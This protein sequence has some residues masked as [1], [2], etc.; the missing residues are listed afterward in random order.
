MIRWLLA[1][2][3]VG[4][5][6]ITSACG[7]GPSDDQCKQLLEHL[8]DLEFKKGGAGTAANEGA[9]ADLAK[10]KAAV[11]E[12]KSAEFMSACVERTHVERVECALAASDVAA[13][14]KCDEQQ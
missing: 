14:Q 3:L 4:G 6:T 8:I 10:Q 13:V 1:A 12:N 9:K 11:L 5:G 2:A 7:K